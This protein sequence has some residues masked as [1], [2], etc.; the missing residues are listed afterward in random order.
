M[1]THS[2]VLAWRI[3]GTGEPGGL[4][5]QGSHRLGPE[6][7]GTVLCSKSI[8]KLAFYTQSLQKF[9]YF[10]VL[11]TVEMFR[12]I[13]SLSNRSLLNIPT[14]LSILPSNSI[15]L[16]REIRHT[17]NYDYSQKVKG[18]KCCISLIL[19]CIFFHILTSMKFRFI[20]QLF[21]WNIK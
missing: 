20:L 3:P 8:N 13:K 5:S 2:S 21:L 9:M 11:F 6:L 12:I 16:V 14:F 10:L 19:H 7:F 15:S 1:A 17:H 18:T 4:L